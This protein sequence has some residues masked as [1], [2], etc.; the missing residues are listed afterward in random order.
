MKII[1]VGLFLVAAAFAETG[2]VCGEYNRYQLR[3]SLALLGVI[4]PSPESVLLGL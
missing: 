3:L 2:Q 1:A 4:A